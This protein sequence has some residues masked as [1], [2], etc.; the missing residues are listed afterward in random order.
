MDRM[1]ESNIHI[2]AL[3]SLETLSGE[4]DSEQEFMQRHVGQDDASY[5]YM[6]ERLKGKTE[7]LNEGKDVQEILQRVLGYEFHV[8]GEQWLD[9]MH[10]TARKRYWGRIPWM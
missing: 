2:T 3:P 8:T 5:G 10:V 7:E 6:K 9:A 4:G 1:R